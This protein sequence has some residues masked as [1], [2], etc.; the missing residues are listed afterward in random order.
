MGLTGSLLIN[1]STVTD[2]NATIVVSGTG[3]TADVTLSLLMLPSGNVVANYNCDDNGTFASATTASALTMTTSGTYQLTAQGG[4][5]SSNNVDFTVDLTLLINPSVAADA[6][7]SITLSGANYTPNGSVDIFVNGSLTPSATYTADSNGNL[8]Q[9][10][11]PS[12]L[13]ISNDTTNSISAEDV[14]TTNNTSA[15]PTPLQVNCFV[16]GTL[17]DVI[18]ASSGGTGSNI[19]VT[20][21]P[22]ETIRRWRFCIFRLFSLSSL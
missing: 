21:K 19:T 13:G 12:A 20:Q 8:S 2:T 11:T 7:T 14:T 5:D 3:F 10:I 9:M 1:P 6:T 22:I 16:A 15:T 4:L 17:I 18:V